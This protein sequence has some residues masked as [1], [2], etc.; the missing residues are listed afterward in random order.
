[1]F[2]DSLS[3]EAEDWVKFHY[4]RQFLTTDSL[5]N[6]SPSLEEIHV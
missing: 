1:M 2:G 5:S 6:Q 3:K 4:L